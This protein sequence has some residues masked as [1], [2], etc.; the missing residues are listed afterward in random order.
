VS[1]LPE[2]LRQL[3][4][5]ASKEYD[6]EKLLAL[7]AEINRLSEEYAAKLKNKQRDRQRQMCRDSRKCA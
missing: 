2:K 3:C 6:S 1:G 7:L 5:L 4:E